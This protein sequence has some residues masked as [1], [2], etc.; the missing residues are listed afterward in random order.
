MS[1]T[2]VGES[3][4]GELARIRQELAAFRVGSVPYLNAAPL[5]YGIADDLIFDVP[6]KL[7]DRFARGELDAALIPV[8]EAVSRES[9]TIADDIAIASEGEVFSVFLAS[10]EPVE[11]LESVAL[12]PNSRTSSHLLQCLFAEFIQRDVTFTASPVDDNQARLIIGDPAIDFHRS[13][14]AAEWRIMDLGEEWLRRTELPFV[15]A[16]WVI[17]NGQPEAARLADL[18]RR[19]KTLGVAARKAIARESADPEFTLRYLTENVRFDLGAAAKR[20]IALYGALL[21]KHGLVSV[22]GPEISYV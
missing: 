6:A 21:R 4:A 11:E 19:V 14:E 10:R 12:D 20:A 2:G 22:G 1:A 7:A 16:C 8:F 17:R 13:P 3:A 5:T 9:A 15:F 18:L